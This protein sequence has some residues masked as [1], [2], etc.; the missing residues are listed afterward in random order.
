MD[1]KKVKQRSGVVMIV[2]AA[3]GTLVAG[4][5]LAIKHSAGFIVLAIVVLLFSFFVFRIGN[6]WLFPKDITKDKRKP[7]V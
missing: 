5:I 1:S 4:Q 6:R 2:I 7:K 3:L